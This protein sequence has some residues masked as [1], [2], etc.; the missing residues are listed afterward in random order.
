MREENPTGGF[1]SD[2]DL[3][4]TADK[5]RV[6]KDGDPA[7]AFLL[8]NAGR[9]LPYGEAVRYGLIKDA[10]AKAEAPAEDKAVKP[11]ENK[12]GR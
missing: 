10:D 11:A 9:E 8:V 3:Y 2:V 6:V 4:W 5:S 1:V 12:A 7:A